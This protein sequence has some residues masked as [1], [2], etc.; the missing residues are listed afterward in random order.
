MGRGQCGHLLQML[1]LKLLLIF[2]HQLLRSI[3]SSAASVGHSIITASCTGAITL[4]FAAVGS[5]SQPQHFCT[6]P[7]TKITDAAVGCHQWLLVY[8]V[9]LPV[10]TSWQR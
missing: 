1:P 2:L 8:N 4:M 5:D 9:Q 6:M 10:E 3:V 7:V